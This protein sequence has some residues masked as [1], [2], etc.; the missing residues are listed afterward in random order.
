MNFA[1]LIARVRQW[2]RVDST[3][4]TADSLTYTKDTINSVIKELISQEDAPVSQSREISFVTKP[5]LSDGT[6]RTTEGLHVATLASTT[7][8]TSLTP[9]Q[10]GQAVEI[11]GVDYRVV[12]SSLGTESPS[13]VYLDR[14]A[15]TSTVA[16]YTCYHERYPLPADMR[17][18]ESL[19]IEGSNRRRMQF[20]T[21]EKFSQGYDFIERSA[22]VPSIA[23]VGPN[24]TRRWFEVTA[25]F[26]VG[27]GRRGCRFSVRDC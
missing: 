23:A 4:E 3:S 7:T 13:Y 17:R 25:T 18:I 5:A 21:A 12:E 6:L 20:V 27:V 24:R 26:T 15:E 2:R 16:T 9:A 1:A 11:A 8:I 14:P 19:I 10:W 22:A